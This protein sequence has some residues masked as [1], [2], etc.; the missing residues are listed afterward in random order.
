MKTCSKFKPIFLVDIDWDQW[1][2][3][4]KITIQIFQHNLCTFHAFKRCRFSPRRVVLERVVPQ[5]KS[6]HSKKRSK[7]ASQLYATLALCFI[8]R[9]FRDD[10]TIAD[11]T[12]HVANPGRVNHVGMSVPNVHQAKGTIRHDPK[13][14][15]AIRI[16]KGFANG[17]LNHKSSA[18]TASSLEC[19][20]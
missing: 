8:P 15:H 10:N 14:T 11:A 20:L 19:I 5:I 18:R 4:L 12:T 1:A 17:R 2:R 6:I 3:R 9:L 16:S 13:N 7:K